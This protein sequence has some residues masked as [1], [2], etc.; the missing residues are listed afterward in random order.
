MIKSASVFR[1]YI[2]RAWENNFASLA[3]QE[4]ATWELAKTF[5]HANSEVAGFYTKLKGESYEAQDQNQSAKVG[6]RLEKQNE[7][8][9]NKSP[10]KVRVTGRLFAVRW[11]DTGA[12][13][14]TGVARTAA[15]SRTGCG[16]GRVRSEHL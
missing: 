9:S 3:Q 1:R 6:A 15:T 12:C 13:A 2:Q 11:R 7:S 5:L 8:A 16:L 4:N 14:R 10:R